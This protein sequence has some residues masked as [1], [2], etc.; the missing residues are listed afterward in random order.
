MKKKTTKT[1]K[2][3]REAVRQIAKK[4]LSEG[5]T[6]PKGDIDYEYHEEHLPQQYVKEM[7]K[8]ADK[9]TSQRLKFHVWKE[10]WCGEIKT[11]DQLIKELK[12]FI[13]KEKHKVFME[14]AEMIKNRYKV[15]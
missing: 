5:H 6:M 15:K 7:V 2:L 4:I 10:V 3:L 1:E 13:P 11:S 14:L 9:Y 12:E 8:Y